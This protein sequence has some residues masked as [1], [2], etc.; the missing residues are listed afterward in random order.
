MTSRSRSPRLWPLLALNFFMADMQSGI[1]PF[2]GVFLQSHGWASGMIGTAMTIGNVAGMLMT[3]PIGG[4]ID[5]SRNKRMWVVIPGICVVAASA[6]ILISQN[7]WA[8]TASQIAQSLASAAIVP[9]VTGITLGMVKQKG[10]NQQNG[11]NQAFN[12]AGNMVGAA[13]SGYLGWTYGYVA[14]F[15]LA[16]VFGAI[17]IACVLMIPVGAIDDR[18]ARGSKEDDSKAPP[19]A[20][21]MLLKHKPL[22]VLALALAIF[23]LGNAAIVPL[24]GLAAVADG[25]ANGPSF[26]ATT[27]VIAQG[28]MVVT[29]LIAMKVASKRNY[30][31]VILASFMFLPIRGVLAFFLTGWWG[32]VPVQVLDGIGTGL[33]TVAVPGMVAR[34]LNGTGRINLGQ[35]A[36]IT[37]QGVGASLSPALG[38]W[39]AEWIGYGPTFLL[40]GGFGI[41]SIALWLAFGAAVKKY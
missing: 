22:L 41:A 18:V 37:V 36:V 35:G 13:L 2:V 10:F 38:G 40:L 33:Q 19:D 29:S 6:I 12:H 27:V 1:G 24:Y 4:F 31:P 11:R 14:V 8:V 32:V 21:K 39:I 26:V 20:M 23:H 28:V 34:S 25:Q 16:A 5:A 17:A 15:V 9:A 3:T 30:W 7:F